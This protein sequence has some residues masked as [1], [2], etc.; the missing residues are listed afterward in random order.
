MLAMVLHSVVNLFGYAIYQN[1]ELIRVRAGSADDG[2]I[3]EQGEPLPEEEALFAK[4][5]LKD[6][7]RIYRTEINGQLEEFTEDT[8]GE[9]FVFDLSQRFLGSRFDQFDP[10]DLK[11]EKFTPIKSRSIWSWF[12][13][14]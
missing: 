12:K 11:M 7:E 10:W 6:G 8:F 9:E 14:S 1:G 5:V 2:L 13:K 3:I 4:S